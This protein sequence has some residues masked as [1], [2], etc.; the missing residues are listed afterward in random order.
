[1]RN[2]QRKWLEVGIG[3]FNDSI[4]HHKETTWKIALLFSKH[5]N[6]TGLEFRLLH[7]I[8]AWFYY[9]WK[10]NKKRIIEIK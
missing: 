8:P 7:G 10:R 1:M 4:E 6:L 9:K 3:E 2:W 5:K